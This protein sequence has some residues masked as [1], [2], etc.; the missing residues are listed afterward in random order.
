MDLTIHASFLVGPPD[1][2]HEV[3]A[4]VEANAEEMTT[5]RASQTQSSQRG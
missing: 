3:N 1:Q 5:T 2:P 4:E